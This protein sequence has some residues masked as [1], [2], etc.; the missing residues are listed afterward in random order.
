[1]LAAVDS[2]GIDQQ[3]KENF[4]TVPILFFIAFI[5]VG[6]FFIMNVFVGVVCATFNQTKAELGN[7]YNLMTEAQAEWARFS[8]Q[9][10]TAWQP[11]VRHKQPTN[12]I[13]KF[14]FKI[15]Q[16]K[17]FD[18]VIM[19]CILLNTVVMAIQFWGAGYGFTVF[20]EGSNFFF[21]ALFTLEAIFKLTAYKKRYFT[22][23]W[24]TFDFCIVVGTL[25]GIFMKYVA[26]LDIGSV[27]TIIRTFR[28]GRILRLVKGLTSLRI[29]FA[30]LVMTLPSLWN[31]GAIV[32]M[33]FY[34][35]AILG[36]Q[37]FATV[38]YDASGGGAYNEH[39]NFRTFSTAFL[40]LVRCS[41]GE[42][43][44]G[45]MYD[46][47]AT[48]DGCLMDPVYDPESCGFNDKEGCYPLQ[49]CGLQMALP[50]WV[51]FTLTVTYVMLNLFIGIV[52]DGFG[53]SSSQEY[54]SLSSD[55]KELFLSLW[56][57]FDPDAERSITVN[58]LEKFVMLL[59][60]PMGYEITRTTRHYE[61]KAMITGLKL[62]TYAIDDD[63]RVLFS[64]VASAFAKR[65]YECEKGDEFEELDDEM[66]LEI[67][68]K[69]STK[70]GKKI[71]L[72]GKGGAHGYHRHYAVVKLLL[73]FQTFKFRQNLCERVKHRAGIDEIG[74]KGAPART[75]AFTEDDKRK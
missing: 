50:F 61:I 12:P 9:V 29:L 34:M 45:M 57:D 4:N 37:L 19:G 14:C 55:H 39:G 43:W 48:P 15:V 3:P 65:V 36:V 71:T 53:E 2:T 67:K 8:M 63:M 74:G 30:T 33:L 73:T 21:G 20:I 28:V 31:V 51:A 16:W 26:D 6:S 5:I 25:L 70:E 60:P 42:N 54:S 23:G 32:C 40:T 38:Q 52:L 58:E 10:F 59:P 35:F 75:E 64:D 11:V 18:T 46:M 62:P 17:H 56:Q 68:R 13:R 24:N 44:N 41:T 47:L 49:G 27:A 69:R 22:S 1:M 7:K 66:E 72:A